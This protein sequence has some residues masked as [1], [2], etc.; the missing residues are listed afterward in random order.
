M[1]TPP[2]WVKQLPPLTYEVGKPLADFTTIKVGGPAEVFYAPK[3]WGEVAAILR[4]KPADVPLTVLGLGSNMV[5]RDGGIRGLVLHLAAGC[6]VVEVKGDSLYAEAGAAAGKAARAAREASL[7]GLEFF[8]GIP[9]SI[10]GALKMN[11]GAYGN[12]TFAAL[13]KIWLLDEKG[14]GREV[15]PAFVKPKYRGT[16]L[17]EGWLFKAGLWQ[18]RPGEREAIRQKMREINHARR[19]SQPLHLPSSGSWFKNVVVTAELKEGL[20]SRLRGNDGG[21]VINAWKVVDEAGCR[22]M[23][24][25][26]AMV[27]EEHANFFVNAGG[28]TCKDLEALSQK[29]AATVK[30]KLGIVLEREVRMMGEA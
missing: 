5:I 16:E 13:K 7:T 2:T 11:A 28:A 21:E 25:G 23:R 12:E 30:E 22:G 24:V 19:S 18:L 4:A 20:D 27:S 15:E 9:G 17:P 8:G 3:D 6:D 29:V 14:E 10:G 1:E 26:G